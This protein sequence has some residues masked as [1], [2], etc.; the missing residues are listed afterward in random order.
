M[1]DKEAKE[2]MDQLVQLQHANEEQKRKIND[3][4]QRLQSLTRG[5]V[6]VNPLKQ[7]RSFSAQEWGLEN[8]IGLKLIHLVGIIV[9]VIGLS[10]GVKYAVDRNLISETFRIVLAYGAGIVLYILSVRLKAKYNFFSAILFSGAMA[11]LYFTTYAAFVYYNLFSFPLAFVLMM[12]LT[13]F[14]VVQAIVYNRQEIAI[15]GLVGAYAIPFLISVNTE[16]ADLFFFY[17]ALINT[18]V[19]YLVFRKDWKLTGRIA[20]ATTWL[21]L[22]GWAA[23]RYKPSMQWTGVG[24]I[25]Y[26]FILFALLAMSRLLYHRK[27]LSIG[28]SYQLVLNNIALYIAALFVFGYAFET[29]DIAMITLFNAAV[30]AMQ[31]IVLHFVFRESYTKRMMAAL[32]FTFLVLFI[33]FRWTGVTVTML[34]LLLAVV[35]FVLGFRLHSVPVRMAAIS[36]IGITLAKLLLL[37]SLTFTPVQKIISYI[38]L[39]VLLLIVSFFYQKFKDRIF[40]DR[41]P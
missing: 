15:L 11:S 40:R 32:S 16:R 4:Y 7:T 9:L 2:L 25:S 18:A 13:V 17:I 30:A 6:P 36:L 14:T 10:I 22:I 12:A 35:V 41:E 20:Q 34:W 23:L 31:A 27:P 29:A 19:A 3:L 33:A 28:D 37:D 24:F 1:D 39:G 5:P 38:V 21:L 26:F 8:F